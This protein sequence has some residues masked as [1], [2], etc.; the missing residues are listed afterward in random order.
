MTVPHLTWG[1]ASSF[2]KENITSFGA[3]ATN[4]F[5][6][7]G[8]ANHLITNYTY[9]YNY[10]QTTQSSKLINILQLICVKKNTGLRK[11]EL[12][13]GCHSQQ[14]DA[15]APVKVPL[16]FTRSRVAFEGNFFKNLNLS[17]GVEVRYFTPYRAN[18]YSPLVGQFTPQDTVTIKNLP[19]IHAFVHFRIKS[20]TGFLRAENLN[21]VSFKNGFGFINNNFA[22][23]HIP[24]PGLVIKFGVRWWFVN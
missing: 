1:I 12:V 16:L 19:D 22:A 17:T 24:T 8:F 5:V 2:N 3:T 11:M 7:L 6:Q 14:T 23:P 15:A 10:Y 13:P 21:T 4:P 20:F 18:N 9:F